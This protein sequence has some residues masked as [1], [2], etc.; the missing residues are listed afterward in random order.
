MERTPFVEVNTQR[1]NRTNDFKPYM[2]TSNSKARAVAAFPYRFTL[3]D[4]FKGYYRH[5]Y[6]HK[7]DASWLPDGR[8]VNCALEPYAVVH[9]LDR[10]GELWGA[11][12]RPYEIVR[13][14]Y[15]K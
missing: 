6:R 8:H 3:L 12:Q 4:E 1:N 15:H 2:T 11:A 14:L 5:W 10:Y 9:Q 7:E 13:D